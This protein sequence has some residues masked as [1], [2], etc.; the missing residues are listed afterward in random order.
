M[1]HVEMMFIGYGMSNVCESG[2]GGSDYYAGAK[3]TDSL[4][5]LASCH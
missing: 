2:C 3:A 4:S 5:A 1:R